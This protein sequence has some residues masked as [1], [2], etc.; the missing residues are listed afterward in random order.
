MSVS[1]DKSIRCW[2]LSQEGKCVKTLG[3]AHEHFVSAI[4]WAPNVVKSQGAVGNGDSSGG[5]GASSMALVTKDDPGGGGGGGGPGKESIRC[6]I[7]TAS[8]DLHVRVFAS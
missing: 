2:D 3:D 8:V 1:D 4:R 7:A 6:V 5:Q